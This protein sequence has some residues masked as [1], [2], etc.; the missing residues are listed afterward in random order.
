MLRRHGRD[1]IDVKRSEKIITE[2]AFN[3]GWKPAWNKERFL[4]N[5]DDEVAAVVELRK[6]KSSLV[7]S[8]FKVGG[9]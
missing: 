6:A 3:I 1:L 2:R 5:I 7:D 4:Q 9:G 8:L